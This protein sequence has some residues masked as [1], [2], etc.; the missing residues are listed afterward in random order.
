MSGKLTMARVINSSSSWNH[1]TSLNERRI[2][3]PRPAKTPV[4]YTCR[5]RRNGNWFP[6]SSM[7]KVNDKGHLKM[8]IRIGMVNV[9]AYTKPDDIE[10]L[11]DDWICYK[12][13]RINGKNYSNCNGC[14]G[15]KS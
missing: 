13:G 14:G 10:A 12:C 2:R 3:N 5:V 7:D 1:Q 8:D 9:R 11:N 15:G 6:A 4:F